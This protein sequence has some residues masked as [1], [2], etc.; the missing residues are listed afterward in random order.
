MNTNLVA[1]IINPDSTETPIIFSTVID[2]RM[3][4]LL[5]KPA[6]IA[7]CE[8]KTN[9]TDMETHWALRD[10]KFLVARTLF[11][12]TS[13]RTCSPEETVHPRHLAHGALSDGW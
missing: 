3:N 5:G 12:G 4:V 8:A 6:I 9:F 10:S 2:G 7:N 1:V 13:E 11:L